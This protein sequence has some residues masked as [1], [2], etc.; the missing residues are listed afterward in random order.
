MNRALN[1]FRISPWLVDC[2][3]AL[4]AASLLV[5]LFAMPAQA[6]PSQPF[7]GQYIDRVAPGDLV[8]G[9]DAY[10]EIREDMP[11]APLLQNGDVIG[12]V[13]VT[14]D[15]VGTT[16]YSGKPIHTL[17][18]VDDQAK[19]LGLDL[20]KHSEPI[21]LIGIPD[22]EIKAMVA[23]YVGMDLVAEAEAG[24]SAH[25]LNIISG[26]TVTIM[27][28]DDSIVRAGLKVARQ[29]GL[30]GL[31]PEEQ[32]GPRYEIAED[33]AT[34]ADWMEME[35]DGTIRRLSLDVGQINAAFEA[36][37]DPR[38]AERALEEPPETTFIDMHMALVQCPGH[39]RGGA[40]R[41]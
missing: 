38:A 23:D 28:I 20:V 30:G 29:L 14:S 10:G 41:A 40:G 15:F 6:Q 1:H 8:E 13:F 22:S 36:V 2:L 32:T 25:D 17:V 39:R 16:G 12:H 18:A 31:S 26:A 4:L 11:V 24:G 19:V 35:G 27:V 34:P 7:L 21:V 37:D 5:W 33:A 3:A 9:A